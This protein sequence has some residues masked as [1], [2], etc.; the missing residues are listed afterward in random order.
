MQRGIFESLKSVDYSDDVSRAW[1]VTFLE[2]KCYWYDLIINPM[3]EWSSRDRIAAELNDKKALLEK[4]L[5]KRFIYFLA[6]RPKV[7]FDTEA[8]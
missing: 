5:D 3:E 4:S 6:T 1:L 8:C 7:R 2:S